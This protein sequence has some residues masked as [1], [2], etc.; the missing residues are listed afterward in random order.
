MK[1]PF[2]F[3]GLCRLLCIISM[4]LE[5][6]FS[7]EKRGVVLFYSIVLVCLF[8]FLFNL[9][10]WVLG[11]VEGLLFWDGKMRISGHC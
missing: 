6:G 2:H 5:L 10:L 3:D 7:K 11:D 4:F 8:C 1:T 9:F